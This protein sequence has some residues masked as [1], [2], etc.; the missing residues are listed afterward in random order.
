MLIIDSCCC[1]YSW[2][3]ISHLDSLHVKL[4]GPRLILSTS[5]LSLHISQQLH[6]VI[7]VV[8]LRHCVLLKVVQSVHYP[9]FFLA[10]FVF[11]NFQRLYYK[12]RIVQ[13]FLW[14]WTHVTVILF[15]C[16]MAQYT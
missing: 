8:M 15:I 1:S 4:C 13:Q 11:R 12:R 9:L 3:I 16:H 14:R 5:S 10:S 6:S 2:D 7:S